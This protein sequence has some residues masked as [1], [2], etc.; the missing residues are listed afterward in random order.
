[1]SG[2]GKGVCLAAC[3]GGGLARSFVDCGGGVAW[4]RL[5]V[6]VVGGGGGEDEAQKG[7]GERKGRIKRK[8]WLGEADERTHRDAVRRIKQVRS[9]RF[10]SELEGARDR[11]AGLFPSLARNPALHY[12]DNIFSLGYG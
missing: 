8:S 7:K 9:Q 11:C 4:V 12:H 6:D 1:V 10:G 3:V 2:G 5:N